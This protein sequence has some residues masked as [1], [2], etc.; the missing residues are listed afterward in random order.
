MLRILPDPINAVIST[1]AVLNHSIL[2]H[3][4]SIHKG[5]A[6]KTERKHWH[7]QSDLI[8]ER[9]AADIKRLGLSPVHTL[10]VFGSMQKTVRSL[11][12]APDLLRREEKTM[13]YLDPVN[14]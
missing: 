10:E 3:I 9:T 4:E 8:T 1:R 12:I 7:L 2:I 14:R 5:I 6:T 13:P 11:K